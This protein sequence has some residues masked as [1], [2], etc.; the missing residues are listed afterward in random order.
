MAEDHLRALKIKSGAVKRTTKEYL[1]YKTELDRETA[2]LEAMKAAGKD[3]Y[4]IKQQAAVVQES[5]GMIPETQKLL[6][7]HLEELKAALEQADGE[8]PTD[9]EH[10]VAAFEAVTMANT[11]LTLE[12][13]AAA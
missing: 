3:E 11:A 10:R 1:S 7:H 6:R 13:P 8:L 2:T 4:D 9:N 12:E 5:A